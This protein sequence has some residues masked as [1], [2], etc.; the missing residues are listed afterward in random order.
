MEHGMIMDHRGSSDPQARH[1]G[2]V[3]P[4]LLLVSSKQQ[5]SPLE[6]SARTKI[7]VAWKHWFVGFPHQFCKWK[8]STNVRV[9]IRATYSLCESLRWDVKMLR[10][11]SR[12]LLCAV[13]I[14]WMLIIDRRTTAGNDRPFLS[15]NCQIFLPLDYRNNKNIVLYCIRDKSDSSVI[16]CESDGSDG[17]IDFGGSC[18]GHRYTCNLGCHWVFLYSVL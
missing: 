2:C 9:S 1:A 5:T 17:D 12:L 7:A 10:T 4:I 3:D 16:D 18:C 11:F 15:V 6:S 14:V 13:C 8:Q